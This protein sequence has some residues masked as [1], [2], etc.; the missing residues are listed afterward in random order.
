MNTAI[1]KDQF[2]IEEVQDEQSS[3]IQS[4]WVLGIASLTTVILFVPFVS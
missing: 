2:K 3:L 4:L 1:E